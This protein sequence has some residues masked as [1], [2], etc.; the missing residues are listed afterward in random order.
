MNATRGKPVGTLSID[1][2]NLWSYL[3]SKGD[4]RWQAYPSFLPIALPRVQALFDELAQSATVFVVGRDAETPADAAAIGQLLGARHE[5][6]NHSYAHEPDFH[7]LDERA[8]DDAIARTEAALA[9]LGQ[10][11]VRG[12]RAPSFRL[13]QTILRVLVRRGYAYDASTFPN[14]L[15]GLARAWQH[16]AFG[17]DS[18]AA[19]TLGDL[20]GSFADSRRPLAP[21]RWRLTEGELAELPVSTLP[22]LRL[23]V[24]WTYLHYL[25]DTA[26]AL[27]LAYVRVHILLCRARGA[28]PSLLMHA[29]DF[30]GADDASCPRFMPGMRRS[31]NDKLALLRRTLGLYRDAFEL[32][33]LGAS[34]LR[35]DAAVPSAI[36]DPAR[37]HLS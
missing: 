11:T 14:V 36:R 19:H 30:I 33:T 1:L 31:A 22:L 10:P 12:F 37:S 20:Y 4:P 29:T 18:Q 32:T 8:V 9:A 13:S 23:P 21:Y 28:S 17:L 24:H 35:A 34:V 27:A 15:G 25:A 26:P 3:R 16:R 2:D 7:L 5:P 6:G